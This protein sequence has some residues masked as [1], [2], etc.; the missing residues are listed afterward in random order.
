M[1]D[2]SRAVET[3]PSGTTS[4]TDSCRWIAE[5]HSAQDPEQ[6][7]AALCGLYSL[8]TEHGWA[9]PPK[10]QTLLHLR[11]LAIDVA[12]EELLEPRSD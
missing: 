5:A 4:F 2:A 10:A 6:M 8:L 7:A 12:L 9:P 11:S 1:T 3:P